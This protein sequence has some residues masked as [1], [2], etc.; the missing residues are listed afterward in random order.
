MQSKNYIIEGDTDGI[1]ESDFFSQLKNMMSDDKNAADKNE[2]DNCCLLTKEPLKSIHIVLACG[3]KFN[4]VPLYREV[5]AQKTIGASSAGY[6]TSHSLKRNEI[7]CPYC[8]N[9]QDKLLPY[10]QYDGVKRMHSINHPAKM[11]M[12]SQLCA[13]ST[14]SASMVS[15]KGRKS[16]PCKECAVECHNGTFVCKKH[17]EMSL[18]SPISPISPFNTTADDALLPSSSTSTTSSVCGAILRYGKNKGNPC[19]NPPSC[20]IHL[21][22]LPPPNIIMMQ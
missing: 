1:T 21:A 15:N 12:S 9:V 11:S 5:I 6:Y 17:Y 14:K 20:R 2:E 4:Y 19:S 7:K 13:Y 16:A 18:I 10:L 8:R 22:A 3:H